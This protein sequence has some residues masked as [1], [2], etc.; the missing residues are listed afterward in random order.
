[1]RSVAFL[2]L[3]LLLPAC[4]Q[5]ASQ[6]PATVYADSAYR[7]YFGDPPE[8]RAGQAWSRVAFLPV[9]SGSGLKPLPFFLYRED[10]QLQLLLDQLTGPLLR[11]GPGSGLRNP[12]PPGSRAVTANRVGKTR[13]IN[14]SLPQ[15]AD[16]DLEAMAAVLVETTALSEGVDKVVL[17]LNGRPWPGMPE[18]GFAPDS[19][20]IVDP[21]PP[22]PVMVFAATD[23]GHGHPGE[24][25]VNFD[26]PVRMEA[27]RLAD[28]EGKPVAGE[29]FQ[30]VFNMAVVL[31]PADPGQIHSGSR[32]QV[33]WQATDFKGRT[34]EGTARL[35]VR[36]R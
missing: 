29:Q 18:G 6:P 20:R 22:R 27:F 8:V 12:F 28:A 35:E 25:L 15:G 30:S 3:L 1:M 2:V 17:T 31:H 14:L 13:E 5:K 32:V 9:E 10:G 23:D 33:S 4:E 19:R 11:P 7:L 36:G 16:G 21:G 26:R 34:G 24:I